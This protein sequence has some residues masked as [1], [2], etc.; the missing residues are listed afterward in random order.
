M[1]SQVLR[2]GMGQEG[3]RPHD[4]KIEEVPPEGAKPLTWLGSLRG[5][6]S[7]RVPLARERSGLSNLFPA[8]AF[9]RSPEGRTHEQPR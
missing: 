1:S 4:G 3:A 5:R 6:R 7:A 8:L 9:L 2:G